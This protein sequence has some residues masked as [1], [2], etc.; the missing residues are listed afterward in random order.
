MDVISERSESNVSIMTSLGEDPLLL[1]KLSN[2]S[3]GNHLS[4]TMGSIGSPTNKSMRVIQT[5]SSED[6][7]MSV[8][9]EEP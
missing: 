3:Q 8:I 1:R 6:N 4:G 2:F 5:E 7:H 9:E